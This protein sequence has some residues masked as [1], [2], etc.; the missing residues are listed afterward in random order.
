MIKQ[1]LQTK[2]LG[3]IREHHKTQAAYARYIGVSRQEIT[4]Y[5]TGSISVDRLEQLIEDFGVEIHMVFIATQ[6]S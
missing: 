3:L 5:L 4:V 2:L 6:H 1:Q